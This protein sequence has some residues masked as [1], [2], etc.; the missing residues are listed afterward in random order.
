MN[1]IN[2][3]WSFSSIE[4]SISQ[5]FAIKNCFFLALIFVER[6]E[7]LSEKT[8]CDVNVG[9]VKQ[10]GKFQTEFFESTWRRSG[11]CGHKAICLQKL[12]AVGITFLL[13]NFREEYIIVKRTLTTFTNFLEL[14]WKCA[15]VS[16]IFFKTH[17][18][19]KVRSSTVDTKT[20]YLC[21]I[22]CPKKFKFAHKLVWI[23]TELCR[24]RADILKPTRDRTLLAW[25]ITKT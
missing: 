10:S 20:K 13:F 1:Q 16:A 25:R 6:S 7:K 15:C 12:Q 3:I 18:Q 19:N 5:V 4:A 8:A 21:I 17:S 24:T 9:Q 22:I 11:L 14:Y 2:I 23:V